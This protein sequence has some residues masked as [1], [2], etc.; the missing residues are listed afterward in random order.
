MSKYS[1]KCFK[2]GRV[3]TRCECNKQQ[4][5]AYATELQSEQEKRKE[6]EDMMEK[7]TFE[8]Q[9]ALDSMVG[10]LIPYH[11][12][13]RLKETVLQYNNYKAKKNHT[14]K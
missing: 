4:P 13:I 5:K 1:G 10:G 7:I 2:C 11:S 9:N 3:L 14:N 6:A 8:I 12:A